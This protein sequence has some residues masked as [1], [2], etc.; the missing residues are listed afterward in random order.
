MNTFADG[1]IEG[2]RDIAPSVR[3]GRQGIF[4]GRGRLLGHELLFRG[5]AQG[6]QDPLE[7]SLGHDGNAEDQATSH[8]IA[9]TF[10]DFGIHELSAGLPLYINMTRAFLV[11][12]LPMP[13]GPGGVVL[14]ILENITVDDELMDALM[15]LRD[16]G[17]QLAVDDFAGEE[18]RLPLLPLAQVI[19]LDLLELAIPLPQLVELVRAH[20]PAATILAERVETQEIVDECLELGIDVFQGYHFER[21]AVFER[22]RLTPSQMVCMRL[23]RILADDTAEISEIEEIVALDPGMSLRVLRTANS[24]MVAAPKRITSLRHALTLL[25]PRMLS[26]WVVLTLLGGVTRERREDLVEILTRASLCEQLASRR[27][28]V[29]TG[30]AY[31][32]GMISGVARALRVPM[33]VVASP[34]LVGEELSAALMQGVGPIG[35]LIRAISEYDLENDDAGANLGLTPL[36]MS[37]QYLSSWAWAQHTLTNMLS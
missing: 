4:S 20:A 22:V 17:Y 10:G 7:S 3:I 2:P 19:K 15:D 33:D 24:V 6:E 21:P 32:A 35:E 25:G 18:H 13:F 23:M 14:E 29:D 11:G 26:A 27:R 1:T 8:V 16:L 5:L 12:D 31:T 28:G 9:A 34:D 37:Q 30:T 36:Q